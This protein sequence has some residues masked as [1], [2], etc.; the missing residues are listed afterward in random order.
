M[1]KLYALFLI[2]IGI[3]VTQY[4]ANA[5]MPAELVS[6]DGKCSKEKISLEWSTA[7]EL[8]LN[9]FEL[10]RAQYN[11]ASPLDFIKINEVKAKGISSTLTKYGPIIDSNVSANLHYCYKLKMID[12][13]GASSYSNEIVLFV[14]K[15]T[16][17]SI[18]ECD[19]E[20]SFDVFNNSSVIRISSSIPID[21]DLNLFT[22]DGRFVEKIKN[23]SNFVGVDE[24]SLLTCLKQNGVYFIELRSKN[25]RI[26]KKLVVN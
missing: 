14:E 23:Y 21:F 26:I 24:I 13:D 10:Y 6:F 18:H 17:L 16:S 25:K 8:N 1:K 22:Y 20:I 2:F 4:F 11:N 5:L 15:D 3:I 12:K 9:N 19:T 7:S